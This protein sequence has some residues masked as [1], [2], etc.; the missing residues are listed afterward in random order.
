MLPLLRGRDPLPTSPG[1]RHRRRY[2]ERTQRHQFIEEHDAAFVRGPGLAPGSTSN[3]PN[4]SSDTP[5]TVYAIMRLRRPPQ[6]H[7]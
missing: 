6:S 2:P 4:A 5:A 1:A 3:L 7:S